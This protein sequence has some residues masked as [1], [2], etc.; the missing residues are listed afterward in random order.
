MFTLADVL[1]AD[2]VDRWHYVARRGK[3]DIWHRE[4]SANETSL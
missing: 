1:D 3:F 4:A 2:P